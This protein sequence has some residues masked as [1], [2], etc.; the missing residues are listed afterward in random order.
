MVEHPLSGGVG[1]P[2][3][4]AF[5]ASGNTWFAEPGCDFAPTCSSSAGPGQ[6]GYLAAGS[7]TPQF[8]KLP[9]I[10]GNQP[11]FVALDG[12][13]KVWF[14]TPNNSMI[15]EFDPVTQTFVGQ[16]AVTPGSGPWDLAFNGGKI[17]YAEHLVSAVGEFDPTTHTYQD[18]QTPTANTQP[19]GIVGN[20]PANPALVWFTENT[21]SSAKVAY[22][23]TAHGDAISEFSVSANPGGMTPH[24]ITLDANG[25]P[26]WSEGWTRAIGTLNPAVATAG[27]CGSSSGDCTGVTEHGLG[28]STSQCGGSH[29]SGI[30]VMNGGQTVWSDDSLSNQIA[31]FTTSNATFT[32]YQ[33]SCV[34][35]HDGLN[36]DPLNNVWWDEEFAN[37]LGELT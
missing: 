26:W 15:G 25:H 13:G 29:V 3:G 24:L 30:A 8:W 1:N 16:W 18:F 11:I 37:T 33:E 23:D 12:A 19:Y 9:S 2:W 34:H 28:P 21:S 36:V 7:S 6:I 31:A 35:T 10:T 14:T 27:V 20:D 32:F 17:W 22:V 4:T 5:D